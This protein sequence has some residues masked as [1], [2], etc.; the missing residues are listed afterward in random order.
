MLGQ[1]SAVISGFGYFAERAEVDGVPFFNTALGVGAKY[2]DPQSKFFASEA[3]YVLLRFVRGGK[4]FVVELK[5]LGGDV[6]DRSEWPAL[7]RR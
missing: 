3:S 6:L 1:G 5:N 2:P 7:D 4:S